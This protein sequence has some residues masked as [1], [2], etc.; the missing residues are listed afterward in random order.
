MVVK[1]SPLGPLGSL[2][3][4]YLLFCAEMPFIRH[5]LLCKI[6]A[7]GQWDML[8]FRNFGNGI[9]HFVITSA[10]SF[11]PSNV[12]TELIILKFSQ[13][14]PFFSL[15]SPK[16]SGPKVPGRL[17]GVHKCLES[18]DIF[19][20]YNLD[21]CFGPSD[22]NSDFVIHHFPRSY[23]FF[24]IFRPGKWRS[25]VPGIFFGV[26]SCLDIVVSIR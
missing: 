7:Q 11:G 23:P 8:G 25:K 1:Y 19:V 10:I 2:N 12:N 20:C 15:F 21:R 18:V 4:F 17:V 16:N 22:I 6:A 5:F 13:Q 3:T 26:Y 24:D 9:Y 14:I